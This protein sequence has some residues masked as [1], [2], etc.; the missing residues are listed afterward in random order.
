MKCYLCITDSI[1]DRKDYFDMLK[2]ALMSARKNTTLHLVCLYDG[3]ENDPVYNLLKEYDVQ[4]IIHEFPFKQEIRDIYPAKWMIDNLGKLI[5]YNQIYGAFMRMEIP[6]IETEDQYVFYADVDVLFLGDIRLEDLPRPAYL[7]AAPEYECCADNITYFNAGVL[8][9]NIEGMKEKYLI[10]KEMMKKRQR[11]SSGL[12]DQGYLNELCFSQMEALPTQYNW[13]PYWGI[14]DK[15]KLI[16][17]HGMKP[18]S[19]MEEAGFNTTDSFFQQIFQQNPTGFAGYVYYTDL[20]FDY[21]GIRHS[22]WVYEHLQQVFNMFMAFPATY[23][24]KITK[25]KKL[26]KIFMF[27]TITLMIAFILLLILN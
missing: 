15:A 17:Y 24:K 12:F 2:V 27:S 8:L 10:F 16:H 5:D 1:V 18:G 19:K 11:N 22:T 20:F 6:A 23:N 25:Y 14:N 13:K 26:F 9:L 4:I 3:K 21:L 7:A